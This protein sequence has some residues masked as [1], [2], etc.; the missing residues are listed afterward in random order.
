MVAFR[1][2]PEHIRPMPTQRSDE[3]GIA[4]REFEHMQTEISSLLTQK[5]RLAQLGLAVAKINHDLRNL[6]QRR[7]AFSQTVS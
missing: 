4:A 3:I 7:A 1:E 2:D 6:P 5:N